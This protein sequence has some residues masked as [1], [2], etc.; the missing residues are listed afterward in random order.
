[1]EPKPDEE[2][3][4]PKKKKKKKKKPVVE[5]K[6]GA[7]VLES[8]PGKKKKPNLSAPAHN[9]PGANLSEPPAHFELTPPP[10][11][12]NDEGDPRRAPEAAPDAEDENFDG[13][14]KNKGKGTGDGTQ[15]HGKGKGGK[16]KGDSMP[17]SSSTRKTGGGSKGGR[18]HDGTAERAKERAIA[19]LEC[20]DRLL[21]DLI[22]ENK[23]L[24][25]WKK[26][27]PAEHDK[28]RGVMKVENGKTLWQVVR[29]GKVIGQISEGMFQESSG[30]ALSMF[31]AVVMSG[32]EK[33]DCLKVKA[34]LV[35]QHRE[36]RLL[37]AD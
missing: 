9:G 18:Q 15:A 24:G 12:P 5:P 3:P 11:S 31:L 27:T 36:G 26:V 33:E 16:G 19:L 10:H 2:G 8:K 20:Q 17:S 29:D 32:F 21:C 1:V 37:N 30:H 4:E 6:P 25:V 34:H 13:I 7:V 28:V 14:E 35:Q 22:K 23:L